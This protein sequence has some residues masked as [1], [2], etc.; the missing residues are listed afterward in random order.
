M[1]ELYANAHFHTQFVSFRFF[2]YDSINTLDYRKLSLMW[3]ELE[4]RAKQEGLFVEETEFV[5]MLA[6]F[7]NYPPEMR[8]EV[9]YKLRDLV[10]RCSFGGP[11]QCCNMSHFKFYENYDL[12]NC[13]TYQAE[14]DR[15]QR[16]GSDVGL[17]LILYIGKF[18]LVQIYCKRIQ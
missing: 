9:G 12:F 11:D 4:Q 17:T 5:S 13:Y 3:P 15:Q 18:V 1:S 7:S 6:Y 2:E 10:V 16:A 14:L 8:G